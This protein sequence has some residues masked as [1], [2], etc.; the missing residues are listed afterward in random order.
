MNKIDTTYDAKTDL[1]KYIKHAKAGTPIYIGSYGE[2]EVVLMAAKSNKAKITFGTA[3][4]KLA[5]K[6]KPTNGLDNDLQEM[7]YGKEWDKA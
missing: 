6:E 3:T 2:H 1:S 5:Y 4:G 7:F